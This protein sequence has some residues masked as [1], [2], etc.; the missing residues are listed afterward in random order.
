MFGLC[1]MKCHHALFTVRIAV[2][3][4]EAVAVKKKNPNKRI[5]PSGKCK[6]VLLMSAL[7]LAPNK[8]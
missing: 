5:I 8:K 6:T 4:E 3:D 2:E 7:A 1:A